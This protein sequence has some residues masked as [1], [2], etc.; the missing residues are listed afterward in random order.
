MRK[1]RF[2]RETSH[3]PRL[4]RCCRDVRCLRGAPG[5]TSALSCAL[6]R[7]PSARG[8]VFVATSRA[9]GVGESD[10]ARASDKWGKSSVGARRST[11]GLCCALRMPRYCRDARWFCVTPGHIS[12]HFRC[13]HRKRVPGYEGV[14]VVFFVMASRAAKNK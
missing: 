12:A 2:A 14:E 3:A 9:T 7:T 13:V 8:W 10:K 11:R 6:P 1:R 4:P 5:H